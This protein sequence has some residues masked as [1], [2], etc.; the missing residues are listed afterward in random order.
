M[1][2]EAFAVSA[3]G[4]ARTDLRGTPIALWDAES[5]G[6]REWLD[7]QGASVADKGMRFVDDGA[8]VADKGMR[9]VDDGASVVEI[10]IPL[11]VPGR[12]S[13]D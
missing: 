9:L 5:A 8:S 10:G 6:R 1:K 3:D 12:P 11:A 13:S 7:E 2:A 4:G